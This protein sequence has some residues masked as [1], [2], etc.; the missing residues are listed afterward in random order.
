[1]SES[2]WEGWERLVE[3]S[4]CESEMQKRGWEGEEGLV[5][6]CARG[7]LERVEN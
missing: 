4:I 3:N 6:S 5:E 1:V 7:G 2:E